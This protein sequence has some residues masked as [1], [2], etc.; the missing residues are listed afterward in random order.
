MKVHEYQAKQIL[1]H[2]GVPVPR[3]GL[4]ETAA[5]AAK[6]AAEIGGTVAVKAQV[7]A[8]G[9][10]K[11]GGIKLAAGPVEAEKIASQMLGMRLVTH[12]T[13]PQGVLVRK[14]LIEEATLIE[15]ELYLGI[16]IDRQAEMPVV[17][18]SEAGGMDIEE[19]AAGSPEKI[20]RAY[21][22]PATGFQPFMGRRLSFGLGLDAAHVKLAG[23]IMAS[24]YRV[25]MDKDCSL[26]EINPLAVTG[27]G[28]LLALD[29]KL[30]FDDNALY[31]HPEIIEMRD[32]SEEA[33]LEVEASRHGISYV[34]L[35]GNIGCMVNGAGLAM[36]TM[37]VIKLAGGEPANFLDVGGGASAAQVSNA[38]R[39]L[40]ADTQV[41][42]VL[43]NIFGGITRCDVV[44]QG[45]LEAAKG[46][47]IDVPVVIRLAGTRLKEGMELLS[48]SG[49]PF[50]LATDLS[51]GARKAV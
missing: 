11:A 29:A 35:D 22:D 23:E 17:M 16:V 8:G 47:K 18:A 19:V 48:T 42:A 4:A 10:G 39:L 36:A 51:D 25:F 7:H 27:D 14:L 49:L 32:T 13:G 30:N 50:T 26:A 33:P 31:R 45:I 41:R 6:V 15:R 21:V 2:F 44:A 37:D 9:R 46:L 38:L 40:L 5:E 20:L 28:R 3:G 24:L 34:K 12:Q 43:I 1:G